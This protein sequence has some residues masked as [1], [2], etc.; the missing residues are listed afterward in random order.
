MY[1]TI[2]LSVNYT[3]YSNIQKVYVCENFAFL[4]KSKLSPC[5]SLHVHAIISGDLQ[6][7]EIKVLSTLL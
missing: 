6:D 4:S 5:V 3:V 1:D 2:E 7:Q